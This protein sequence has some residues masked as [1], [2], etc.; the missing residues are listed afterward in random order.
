[1][2]ESCIKIQEDKSIMSSGMATALGNWVWYRALGVFG[3]SV[4]KG[5]RL[6][7]QKSNFLLNSAKLPDLSVQAFKIHF[8]QAVVGG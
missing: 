3:K 2:A 6:C 4:F 8:S 7:L 5:M 1:M